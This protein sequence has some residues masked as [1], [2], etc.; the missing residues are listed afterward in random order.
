MSEN[1]VTALDDMIAQRNP[2][3]ANRF[4]RK[5]H[6]NSSDSNTQVSELNRFWRDQLSLLHISTISARTCLVDDIAPS[7]WLRHFEQ[8]V[9]PIVVQHDLPAA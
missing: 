3:A 7:D 4:A 9:L 6:C 5:F 8:L 2:G 1:I